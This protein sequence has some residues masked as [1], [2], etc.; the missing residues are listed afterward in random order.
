[1]RSDHAVEIS[2]LVDSNAGKLARWLRMMGYDAL[3]F[4]NIDDSDLVDLAFKE[5][6]VILTKDTQ[7]MR[8]RLVANGQIKLILTQSDDPKEQLH[9][10][11]KELKLDCRL[12]QFTRC[13]ECNQKLVP[14]SKEEVKELVPPYVFRTHTQ[15]M[16]CPACLRVYWQGTHW[17]RMKKEL[18]A[19]A[20]DSAGEK[21]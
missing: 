14:K 5:G 13:L 2:F 4:N 10:V 20:S 6:R 7:I 16:Q 18:E 11:V 9:Q 21:E 12:K 1:M 19:F 3:F 15:Y 17:Q 8:R